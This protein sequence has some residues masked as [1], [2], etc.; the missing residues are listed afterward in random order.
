MKIKEENKVVALFLVIMISFWI[1]TN[2]VIDLN[3]DYQYTQKVF[4]ERINNKK[5]AP[6]AVNQREEASKEGEVEVEGLLSDD[7]LVIPIDTSTQQLGEF[8]AYNS[9]VGQTDNDPF[10]MANG[11]RVFDGAIA[12]NCLAFGDKVKIQGKIYTVSDRMNKRYDCTHFDIWFLE[13]QEAINF[14]RRILEYKVL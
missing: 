1:I 13:K 8:S 2:E 9:E 12:N 7:N 6:D 11:K 14:G 5:D 10:T 4:E 3:R